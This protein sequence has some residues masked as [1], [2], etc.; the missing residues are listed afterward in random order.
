MMYQQ[1]C[2][3]GGTVLRIANDLA[4]NNNGARVLVVCSEITAVIFQGPNEAHIDSLIGQALF[5]DG[6]AAIIVGSSPVAGVEKPLFVLVST[7]QTIIPDSEDALKLHLCEAG[8]T[9]HASKDVPNL[10]SN[11]IEKSLVEAFQPLGLGI[12]DWS[13]IFWAFHQGVKAI[14]DHVEWRMGL[15][16]DK[17]R[18]A[19]HVLSVCG[20]LTSACVLF[21]LDELRKVSGGWA[22]DHWGRARVGCPLWVRARTHH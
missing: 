2:F 1:G 3:A 19:R 22:Q 10:I 21:I 20:N 11:N 17:I 18:A 15:K 7:A 5:G 8:L 14:I 4:E 13:S 6:A 16:P 12:S 9:F